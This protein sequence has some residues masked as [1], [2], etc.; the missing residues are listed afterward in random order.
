MKILNAGEGNDARLGPGLS[1]VA[2][3]LSMAPKVAGS[4]LSLQ[5]VYSK[6]V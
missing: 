3:K 6:R 1:Q 2:A 4:R 5:Y